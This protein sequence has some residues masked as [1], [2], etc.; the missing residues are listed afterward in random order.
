MAATVGT[1]ITLNSGVID[2]PP[3]VVIPDPTIAP[4]DSGL[5]DVPPTGAGETNPCLLLGGDDLNAVLSPSRPYRGE[6]TVPP[7]GG[8]LEG[9]ERSFCTFWQAD[10]GDGDVDFWVTNFWTF[11]DLSEWPQE[12]D[13]RVSAVMDRY[14]ID[15]ATV[16]EVEI[17]SQ[18]VWV[19]VNGFVTW[20]DRAMYV[21]RLPRD[22]VVRHPSA[23]EDF[24]AILVGR[25][26]R[27]SSG[28]RT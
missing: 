1:V 6:W 10:A 28:R 8:G 3:V 12:P 27:A 26:V 20:D 14:G 23:L 18:R 25:L 16:R 21:L 7:M 5:I 2:P 13:Q 11:T 19:A 24:A 15:V 17:G 22:I 4:S 9:P